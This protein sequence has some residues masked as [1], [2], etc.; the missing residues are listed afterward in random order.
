MKRWLTQPQRVLHLD[1]IADATITFRSSGSGSVELDS[2][3]LDA[4]KSSQYRRLAKKGRKHGPVPKR[5]H[6]R[7]RAKLVA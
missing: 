6:G 2:E 7:G 1:E 4:F 5:K 3:V